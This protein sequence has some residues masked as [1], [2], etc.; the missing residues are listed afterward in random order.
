MRRCKRHQFDPWVGKIPWSRKRLP[1]PV[2]LPGKF[3][4]QRSL[5]GYSPWG[6]KESDMTEHTAHIYRMEEGRQDSGGGQLGLLYPGEQLI[7][8]GCC[9][10][11]PTPPSQALVF[12]TPTTLGAET[13]WTSAATW[14][15]PSMEKNHLTQSQVPLTPRATP[16]IHGPVSRN[17]ENQL[18]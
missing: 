1:T 11:P 4:G 12:P 17:R 7:R 3:H 13:S 14:G 6:R 15:S 5:V 18:S 9:W 8:G 16:S 10:A 2:F